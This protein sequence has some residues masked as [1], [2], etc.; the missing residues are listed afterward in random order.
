[1]SE[2]INWIDALPEY[3]R[4]ELL[5]DLSI[6][7]EKLNLIPLE[8]NETIY[9]IPPEVNMLIEVLKEDI[10]QTAVEKKLEEIIIKD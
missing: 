7:N 9:W 2:R 3:V 10:I 6:T 4:Q 5:H 1:M 8:I